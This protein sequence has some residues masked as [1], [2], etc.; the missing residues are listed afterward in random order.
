MPGNTLLTRVPRHFRRR[1]TFTGAAGLGAVGTVAIATV[2][3]E[4]LITH[5]TARCVTTIVTTTA[6]EIEL[7]VASNTAELIAQIADAGDLIATEYWNDATPTQVNA[8][9]AIVDKV[10]AANI[11]LTVGTSPMTAGVIDF[12]MFWL[13]LSADGN[14]A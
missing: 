12:S 6:G 13:P 3:G 1:I 5:L 11:I 10:V 8:S 9:D 7:G 2:T 14:L 4:V